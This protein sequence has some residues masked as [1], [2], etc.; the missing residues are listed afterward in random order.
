LQYTEASVSEEQRL[1]LVDTMAMRANDLAWTHQLKALH[2]LP[3]ALQ[4]SFAAR[5]LVR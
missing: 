5:L 2:A 4:G 1:Q 3:R